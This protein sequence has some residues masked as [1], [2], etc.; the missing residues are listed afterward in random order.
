MKE[1]KL[2]GEKAV[3][4]NTMGIMGIYFF[5]EHESQREG[6]YV[7]NKRSQGISLEKVKSKR[8]CEKR[9]WYF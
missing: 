9:F 3:S 1:P 7:R 5:Q 2:N 8:G 6:V 4:L